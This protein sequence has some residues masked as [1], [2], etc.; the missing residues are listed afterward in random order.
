MV[1]TFL[2]VVLRRTRTL[3]GSFVWSW[4]G[5][6]HYERLA[7]A[8]LQQTSLHSIPG[9]GS[10]LGQGFPQGKHTRI[11]STFNLFPL[12]SCYEELKYTLGKYTT[13]AYVRI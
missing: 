13:V 10:R 8:V 9:G 3:W 11:L 1:G 4:E 7:Y 6:N 5:T 2:E 12:I